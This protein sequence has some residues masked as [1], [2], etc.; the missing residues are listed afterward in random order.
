MLHSLTH[1][2]PFVRLITPTLQAKHSIIF[3]LSFENN[4]DKA[5]FG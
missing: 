2:T 5:S 3:E 4:S 1:P